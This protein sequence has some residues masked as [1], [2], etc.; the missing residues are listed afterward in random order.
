MKTNAARLLDTLGIQDDLRIG[1]GDDVGFTIGGTLQGLRRA[2]EVAGAVIDQGDIRHGRSYSGSGWICR[3][4]IEQ[5][6]AAE[7]DGRLKAGH[8][9]LS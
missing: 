9:E 5:G 6:R 1:G 2:G 4:R 7:M 8:D 3:N